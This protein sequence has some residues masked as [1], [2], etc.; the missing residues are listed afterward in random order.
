[1][2]RGWQAH[3]G[4]EDQVGLTGPRVSVT[5]S[6]PTQARGGGTRTGSGRLHR[7]WRPVSLGPE[8]HVAPGHGAPSGP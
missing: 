3:Q 1:M 7:T 8:Q 6:V 5:G 4:Q 2:E